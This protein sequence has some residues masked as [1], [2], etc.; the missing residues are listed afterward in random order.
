MSAHSNRRRRDVAGS[1]ERERSGRRRGLRDRAREGAGAGSPRPSWG[2]PPSR[3]SARWSAIGGGQASASPAYVGTTTPPSAGAT[4]SV[5]DA[6]VTGRAW[7]THGDLVASAPTGPPWEAAGPPPSPGSCAAV[8][9]MGVVT[10]G[11]GPPRPWLGQRYWDGRVSGIGQAGGQGPKRGRPRIA[12][13][14]LERR[15]SSGP[16]VPRAAPW[17]G[18]CPRGAPVAPRCGAPRRG[19]RGSCRARG[20]EMVAATVLRGAP[21]RAPELLEQVGGWAEPRRRGSVHQPAP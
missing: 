18:P 10:P 6:P 12:R 19:R 4:R 1:A 8:G 17:S 11:G 9:A 15:A 16:P 14:P 13:G 21:H 2:T 20:R 7:I 5:A 3:A